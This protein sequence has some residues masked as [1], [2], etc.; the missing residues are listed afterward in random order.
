MG[1]GGIAVHVFNLCC[2][3]RK[4]PLIRY[5]LNMKLGGPQVSFDP[6]EWKGG[7]AGFF[8]H[9]QRF[10][11]GGSQCGSFSEQEGLYTDLARGI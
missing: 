1:L 8:L 3:P 6:M 7:G 4:E 5:P 9:S 10:I 11:I 2:T